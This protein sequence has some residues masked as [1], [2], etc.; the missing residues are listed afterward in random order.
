MVVF[1]LFWV[2]VL[3]KGIKMSENKAVRVWLI[4]SQNQVLMGKRLSKQGFG[5]FCVP[6]GKPEK[7]ESLVDAA[8][9]ETWEET[10][11]HITPRM[12]EF[13][14][15]TY[16][17]A[18]GVRYVNTHYRVNGINMMPSVIEPDKCAEWRWFDMNNLPQNLFWSVKNLINQKV[19]AE[20]VKNVGK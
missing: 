2:I 15:D 19:F 3:A 14:A 8:I 20:R 5:M 4:N 17:Y 6:G 18:N 13:V 11:I 9:R 16:D 12:L 1:L 10:G 7:N